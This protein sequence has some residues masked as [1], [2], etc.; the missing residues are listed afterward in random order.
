MS[1]FSAWRL[2]LCKLDVIT[3]LWVVG[4]IKG[5]FTKIFKTILSVCCV[6][7][8]YLKIYVCPELGMSVWNYACLSGMAFISS[9]AA[10]PSL[11]GSHLAKLVLTVTTEE[12]EKVHKQKGLL[13]TQLRLEPSSPPPCSFGQSRPQGSPSFSSHPQTQEMK[14]ADATLRSKDL[15]SYCKGSFCTEYIFISYNRNYLVIPK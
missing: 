13:R 10:F 7:K 11:T 5:D 8:L 12:Q 1:Y 9:C 2:C 4:K 15:G 3:T 14:K 6:M